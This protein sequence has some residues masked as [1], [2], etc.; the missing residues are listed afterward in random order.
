MAVGLG[1]F[2]FL[3]FFFSILVSASDGWFLIFLLS[4][5]SDLCAFLRLQKLPFGRELLRWLET[6]SPME[7][8]LTRSR[9]KELHGD[10]KAMAQ[11]INCIGDGLT[12]PWKKA[13]KDERLKT[14][15][16]TNVSMI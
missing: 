16:I 1:A 15:L 3:E 2:L 14:E 10:Q 4:I 8:S 7:S 5:S 11:Y 6:G 12:L 9:K 13:S